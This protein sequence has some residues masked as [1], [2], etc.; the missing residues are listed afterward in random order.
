[1]RGVLPSGHL[2]CRAASHPQLS[3]SHPPQPLSLVIHLSPTLSTSRPLLLW[4]AF[5]VLFP[6]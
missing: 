2:G 6:G 4:D 3:A 1:M 5:P